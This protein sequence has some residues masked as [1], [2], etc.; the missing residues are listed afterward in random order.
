[1]KQNLLQKISLTLCICVLIT[2]K[3]FAQ[4]PGLIISELHINPAGA[5]SPFEYAEFRATK[6]I[7]F[8]TTP[9]SVVLCNN[10]TA[11]AAG[12]IAGGALSYGF[13]INTGTVNPGDVVYVGGSSMAPTG[14]KLRVINTGTTAG[15]GFGNLNTGGVFG[16]GGPSA[17]GIAVFDA[18]IA[19]LTNSTVPID[20]LF[21]GTAVGSATTATGGYELPINDLYA[22]G[23]MQSTSFLGGDPGA[24][25]L[26]ANGVFDTITNTYISARSWNIAALTDGNS[27]VILSN[28]LPPANIAFSVDNQTVLESAE[29]AILAGGKT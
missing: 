4:R 26:V 19:T 3:S 8:A 16:N 22:G 7:N 12:W 17:D 14:V 24:L 6:F 28:V 25:N 10:G 13:S 11:T 15:D 5:D 2:L 18:G 9:Y 21:Y 29:N 1:M 20:A 23:K 27:S